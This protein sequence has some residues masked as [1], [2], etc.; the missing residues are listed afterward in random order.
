MTASS[1][2]N[3]VD[4][5]CASFE[6][7]DDRDADYDRLD[8]GSLVADNSWNAG[9]ILARPLPAT[10]RSSFT[11]LLGVLEVNGDV[12]DRGM[13]DDVGGD[14]MEIVAWLANFLASRGVALQP[15]QWVM[16][17]SIVPTQ[18]P[19]AG[20]TYRFSLSGFPP[21]EVRIS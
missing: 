3:F 7:I 4:L 15:G 13:T 2:R 18:F 6:L 16:T 10:D 11:R 14:P 8:A 1:A 20:D 21:V 9:M 17:G 12:V 19:K 5:A